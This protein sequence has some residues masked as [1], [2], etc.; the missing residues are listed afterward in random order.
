MVKKQNYTD[1]IRNLINSPENIKKAKD[2]FQKLST[3]KI[4]IYGA[5]NAGGMIFKLLQQRGFEVKA[6]F[7]RHGGNDLYYCGKPVYKA[8]DD[9]LSG[10][11]GKDSM[12][13]IAFICGYRELV[14]MQYRLLKM[15]WETIYYFQ[16][17]YYF[18][19]LYN[20]LSCN[21]Q[22]FQSSL[23]TEK[24][25][26]VASFMEDDESC[27]VFEKFFK[28]IISG[29]PE[30][31]SR[32]TEKPQYFVDNVPFTK[33]Y[34]RFID[35]GAFDGDTAYALKKYKR[36]AEAL[37]LFEP[38]A[39]NFMKLCANLKNNRTAREQVLFPCG[40]WK[41]N[42][43]LK[44]RSGINSS[45]GISDNGDTFIQCI[46]I[47]D[48]IGDFAPTFLKMDIEGAEYE[49]L[50]GAEQTIRKYAPDLAISVYHRM[51]HLWQIP[52]LIK[53]IKPTYKFY[54]RSHGLHGMETILYAVSEK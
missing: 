42:E 6:F 52:L 16:T 50:A 27:E 11:S 1:K 35:C 24:I 17:A 30:Y 2:I 19:D 44:F 49:A 31:F 38:D 45:S 41:N 28:A 43:M 20:C 32:P 37:V 8:D 9:E 12:I 5:G 47:D 40:V 15:G 23:E 33:G 25:L 53:T 46:A 51:E 13:I 14:D 48:V 29:N 3:K 54:I 18:F 39:G 34:A 4:Y 10:Q 7:D 22:E 26:E 36:E 21:E